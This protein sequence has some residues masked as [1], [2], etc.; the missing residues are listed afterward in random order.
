MLASS[1]Q[2]V[3]SDS[4]AFI[5]NKVQLVHPSLFEGAGYLLRSLLATDFFVVAK[6]NVKGPLRFLTLLD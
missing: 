3:P 2:D 5:E 4:V 6:C 1:R